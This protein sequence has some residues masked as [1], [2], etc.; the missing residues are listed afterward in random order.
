[1]AIWEYKVITS[2]K[3]GFASPALLEKFLNDL[4]K[5][6]WEIVEF[7]TQSDNAL[8]FSGLARRSTQR[9]WTLEGAAASAAKAEADKL[10]AEF[11]AKFKGVGGAPAGAASDE[12]P[13]AES[14]VAEKA[15][16]DDG[17]RRLRD[18]ER[19]LDP[20]AADEMDEWDKLS[21]EDELPTFFDALKPH[22]R[23]NQR[24]PGMAVGVDFLAKK[25]DLSEEDIKGALLE[26]GFKI[27]DDENEKPE[28]LE[29]DGD[30][31]WLN[32]NRRGELWINTK[33]KPRPAFRVVKGASVA[34]EVAGEADAKPEHGGRS[35]QHTKPDSGNR[36]PE[37]QRSEQPVSGHNQGETRG[38]G[39]EV[40]AAELPHGPA[41]LE[42][43]RPLMRRNR[44]GQGG[45]GSM[46][47]LS[48]ALK[49]READLMAAFSTLGL[50]LPENPSDKPISAEIGESVWWLNKDQ[51][52]G[53]WINGR[54]KTDEADASESMP[55]TP[56]A[57][58]GGAQSAPATAPTSENGAP[59]AAIF[60]TVRPLLKETKTGGF[61]GKV[62]R[63]AEEL[64]K[65]SDDFMASLI[66]AGVKVPEKAREK[67]VFVEQAGEIFWLNKNA[68]NE[69]W[70][71]AKASKFSKDEGGGESGES[72]EGGKK[73]NRRG[74]GRS[75]K[76]E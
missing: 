71:N 36:K 51:R 28:Y 38:T 68:K 27:P 57:S 61:A 46:S 26:C 25:W 23:R 40:S 44:R 7:R 15:A 9:D 76:K 4:G 20:D 52:G 5:E 43:I 73:S 29:Y 37:R 33:E 72:G 35:E 47:F 48:R 67:P 41:L 65:S 6:E 75:R 66:A 16:S 31:F 24:G 13:G 74:G 30:L 32:V 22:M 21:E 53:I 50:A 62:D 59:S 18:T 11:E 34:P 49:C 19:D 1:M 69:L 55:A 39:G 45:S 17:L 42:R 10:R 12:K 3:G 54:E 56:A 63:L 60:S 64:G 70:L 14:L 58:E 2:G 8:A